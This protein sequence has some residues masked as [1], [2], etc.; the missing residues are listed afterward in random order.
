MHKKTKTEVRKFYY[1]FTKKYFITSKPLLILFITDMVL[2]TAVCIS[3]FTKLGLPNMNETIETTLNY[4]IIVSS[5][6][7]LLKFTVTNFM[8]DS[9]YFK[10]ICIYEENIKLKTMEIKTN[11]VINYLPFQF[12]I[13]MIT[14]NIIIVVILNFEVE[15][16]FNDSETPIVKVL[17]TTLSTL[18]LIPSFTASLNKI[19]TIKSGVNNNYKL[20]VRDQFYANKDFIKNHEVVNDYEFIEFKDLSIASKKGLF[21]LANVKD[22]KCQKTLLKH[23]L[24][25]LDTYQEIWSKYSDFLEYINQEHTKGRDRRLAF[26]IQRVFD[27]VFIDMLDI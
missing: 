23:N 21:L 26:L 15:L 8:Y 20:L 11:R 2:F 4:L 18:L 5:F 27:S 10:K 9:M 13:L 12:V 3:F 16:I 22:A 1:D 24:M 7:I 25:V 6:Y 17:V 14:L 19:S